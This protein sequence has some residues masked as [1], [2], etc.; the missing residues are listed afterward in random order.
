MSLVNGERARS[1]IVMCAF[2]WKDA[3]Q[4]I[5]SLPLGERDRVGFQC[6]PH[7][8]FCFLDSYV[9]LHGHV[10]TGHGLGSFRVLSHRCRRA[11]TASHA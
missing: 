2:C 8:E 1:R 10:T 3:A 5:V 6:S 7:R 9:A 4:D 11:H